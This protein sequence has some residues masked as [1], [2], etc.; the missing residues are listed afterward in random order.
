MI[1]ARL[2]GLFMMAPFF[3][4]SAIPM[5]VKAAI[6]ILFSLLM[7]FGL[8][9]GFHAPPMDEYM[10]VVGIIMEFGAGAAMG[11]VLTIFFSAISY[12][13]GIIAPQMGMAISQLVDPSTQQ[14]QP[15][16]STFFSLIAVLFFIAI[17]GH[18]MLLEGLYQSYRL[19]PLGG[20][21]ISS[22][23]SHEL[24]EIGSLLFIIAFK[25]SAPVL[26]VIIFM[27]I[28][29]AIMAR[30]VPQVNVLV[31]GFIVTISVGMMILSMFLPIFNT[32]FQELM[33]EAVSKMMWLLKAV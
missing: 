4:H 14:M 5:Q 30:A 26:A 24:L 17:N 1:N 12:A 7:H 18:H 6:V 22:G 33:E 27:N 9:V 23:F 10:L 11:L 28:G 16:I 15:L 29:M 2:S 3:S 32:F 19:V 25:L 31:V 8:G 20:F 21:T 13:A